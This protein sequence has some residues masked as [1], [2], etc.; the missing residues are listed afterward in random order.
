[1]KSRPRSAA[2]FTLIE[3][4]VV[5]AIIGILASIAAV[6]FGQTLIKSHNA[7][8]RATL[9]TL[10]TALYNYYA[11]N[12]EFPCLHT[13]TIEYSASNSSP[14]LPATPDWIPNFAPKYVKT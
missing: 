2:G 11:D 9:V 14:I 5:V 8:R 10:R 13:G 12:N 4:V 7:Y 3:L 1:M 6:Q